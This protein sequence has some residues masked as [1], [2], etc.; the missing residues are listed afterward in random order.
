M[1]DGERPRS[2]L[3]QASSVLTISSVNLGAAKPARSLWRVH[4]FGKRENS[5]KRDPNAPVVIRGWLCKQDSS[6]L[7]LWKRRWFVL[8]DYCLFYYRDSREEAVLGSIP[9]PSYEIRP[10]PGERKSR[11]FT[12]KAEHRGMRTY[13][14]SADTQEDM[15]GWIRAMSQSA[16]AE[17]DPS[18]ISSRP[19]RVLSQPAPPQAQRF[20]AVRPLTPDLGP[21]ASAESLEIARLSGPH[22][23]A[24][25][26]SAT[27][28][29]AQGEGGSL[30]SGPAPPPSPVNGEGLGGEPRG[31]SSLSSCIR[32]GQEPSAAKRPHAGPPRPS[33][34]PCPPESEQPPLGPL[35]PWEPSAEAQ[36]HVRASRSYSLPP[37]PAE[38][39]G[40]RGSPG[41]S[42]RGVRAPEL[43]ASCEELPLLVQAGSSLARPHTPVGRVDIAPGGAVRGSRTIPGCPQTPADR[44]DLRPAEEPSARPP[45]RYPRSPHPSHCLA[46]PGTPAEESPPQTATLGPALGRQPRSR[47][48]LTPCLLS[49]LQFTDRVYP[50]LGA[51]PPRARLHGRLVSPHSASAGYLQL[52][53][54][55]PLASRPPGKRASLGAPPR[56]VAPLS[57]DRTL[58]A[59]PRAESDTDI[60]LTKLCG[61]DK[62]L[63][64]L[65]EETGQLRAEKEQLEK[66]LEL[67]RHQLD[68]GQGQEL[69]EEK[70]WYQQR[71]L[72]DELVQV[73][74]RLCDL[75]L[76]GERA[77]GDFAALEN[78][79]LTLR[80]T[81]AQIR[82]LGHPQEQGAAQQELWMIDD[83]IAGLGACPAPYPALDPRTSPGFSLAAPPIL[84]PGGG[85]ARSP[86][87]LPGPDGGG[88]HHEPPLRGVLAAGR[89]EGRAPRGDA[90]GS[91]PPQ[92]P[93]RRGAGSPELDGGRPPQ[94]MDVT[95]PGLRSPP[96]APHLP[97]SPGPG[98]HEPGEQR[99]EE[100]P[101]KAITTDPPAPHR[102]RMSVQEQLERMRRHQEGQRQQ[103]GGRLNP[104]GSRQGSLRASAS[105]L[106]LPTH[107][108]DLGPELTQT[109][110]EPPLR[111]G[112]TGGPWVQSPPPLERDRHRIL[113]LAYA[114]ATEASERSKLITGKTPP[115]PQLLANPDPSPEPLDAVTNQHMLCTPTLPR[116]DPEANHVEAEPCSPANQNTA[117][118]ANSGQRAGAANQTSPLFQAANWALSVPGLSNWLAPSPESANQAARL[119]EAANR[120]SP[121]SKVPHWAPP[122]PTLAN[123]TSSAHKA[124]NRASPPL[125]ATQKECG[126]WVPEQ[127]IVGTKDVANGG[128]RGRGGRAAPSQVVAYLGEGSQPI[129]I[130]LLQSSF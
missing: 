80:E 75:A 54:L 103:E 77:W 118:S 8:A 114:L 90:W 59:L 2:S 98:L 24:E 69:A 82:Q 96:A 105:R 63:R 48:G 21:A 128:C 86:L 120:A 119:S 58:L 110:T 1:A 67:L 45:G 122:L 26:L 104:W 97:R 46:R 11:R 3:S 32:R 4:T 31:L 39:R 27:G 113:T 125:W 35:S 52:P 20:E 73:R 12:F 10:L 62:L 64:G 81:L 117:F 121:L 68:E 94:E 23:S 7:K 92:S 83:I 111:G 89:E 123:Q 91:R 115:E 34:P 29:G 70:L 95:A 57:R 129:R 109:H 61:Q 50:S 44:Y 36:G 40:V 55:P 33:P 85:S 6:A 42:S 99:T 102:A 53:P 60:L 127:R 87:P 101:A 126:D 49:P 41:G 5:V 84:E 18:T 130:T 25:S 19:P 56:T 28:R 107:P 30:P 76:D 51:A 74:A 17:N 38:L 47:L 93:S 116:G 106:P 124:S 22:S 100:L 43:A 72:Q 13:H 78:E 16:A 71:R 88:Q 15:N 108:P 37:T 79:L 9:L 112:Q 66:A 14:F 65:E